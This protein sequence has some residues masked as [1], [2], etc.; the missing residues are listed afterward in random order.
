MNKLEKCI[1][2][3]V[4]EE[5]GTSMTNPND[6]LLFCKNNCSGYEKKYSC[7]WDGIKQ[8]KAKDIDMGAKYE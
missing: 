7:Y 1:W 2:K 4:T 8:R 3:I 5:E 6:H